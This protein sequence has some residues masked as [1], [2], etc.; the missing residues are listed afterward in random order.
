[1]EQD[2]LSDF[3]VG[4]I[5]KKI[6][7][8][9]L[10][11]L[12]ALILQAAYGAVDLLVV[13]QFGTTAGLSGVSTG[14]QILNLITLVVTGS[15]MAV[16]VLISRYLGENR[17]D[18]INRLLGAAFTLYGLV[19]II[20]FILM[21][22]G[23]LPITYL[24]QAPKE[25]V[26]LTAQYIRICGSGIFFI[27]AYNLLSAIFRGLGD[28]RSPL[29][30]VG[31]ACIINIIGDLYFVAILHMN[32]AGAALATVLAQ[33]ISVLFA[34][35]L[36]KKRVTGIEL[37]REDF[38][39]NEETVHI[40]KIGIPLALQDLLTQISFV[41]VCAFVN[42]LGLTASSGYG[43]ACKIINFAMLLPSALMQ[44][45]A[46][47]VSMNVGAKKEDRASQG[48]KIS[49]AIGLVFGCLVF[50]CVWFFGDKMCA[51]F[52]KEA[53]VTK[54]AFEYLRG[55][56]FETVVTAILF[57]L[58]GYFNG[59]ERTLWTMTQGILQTFLVRI[60]FAYFMTI[61]Q[62]GLFMIGLASPLATTF[63]VLLNLVYLFRFRKQISLT[64]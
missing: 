53:I 10:P 50:L 12:G 44:S 57:S 4:S 8:F 29:I 51:L 39:F 18:R 20:L 46:A 38:G 37:K 64:K 30:F 27:V 21:F 41:I 11:V 31:I 17:A 59:H 47:F 15:S 54:A 58:L 62:A 32:V 43:I 3:T 34:I 26:D 35:G 2:S 13:G 7:A 6:L 14:S 22:F 16:T 45:N 5:P 25:A 55:F 60:P 56:S 63:G 23:A 61:Q 28:S 48:T 49:I 33:A 40:L 19:A 36:L 42:S 52:T 1:M 9:M 24:M